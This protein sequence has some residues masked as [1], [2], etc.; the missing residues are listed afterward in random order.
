[1][2]A[3]NRLTVRVLTWLGFDSRLK[4]FVEH[5]D[6]REGNIS[7]F[8]RLSCPD[9]GYPSRHTAGSAA[10]SVAHGFPCTAA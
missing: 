6:A 7:F 2:H 8:R 1:M 10:G 5:R 4:F 9:V 3:Y